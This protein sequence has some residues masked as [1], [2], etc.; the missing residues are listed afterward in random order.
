MES[1]PRPLSHLFAVDK[2]SC[3]HVVKNDH[4]VFKVTDLPVTQGRKQAEGCCHIVVHSRSGVVSIH[5]ILLF[6]SW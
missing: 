1:G 5:A 2:I 4:S 3:H 6:A